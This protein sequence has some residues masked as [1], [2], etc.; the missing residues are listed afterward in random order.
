MRFLLGQNLSPAFSAIAASLFDMPTDP[1][2][3]RPEECLELSVDELLR[4]ARPLP[5]RE[6][7]VI[8]DLTEED[9]EAFFEAIKR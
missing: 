9:A 3:R 7:T 8:D 4:R 1:A 5:P 2:A 6:A